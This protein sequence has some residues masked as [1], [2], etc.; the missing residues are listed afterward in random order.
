MISKVMTPDE[1]IAQ[2]K[3]GDSIAVGG[4][5]PV[6]KPMGLIR[7]IAR[8]NLKNLT[9]MSYAALEL[10]LLIGAK[11]V[12]KAIYGFVALEGAPGS[13]GNYQRARQG[14]EI[15]V[16]ELSEGMLL[17]GLKAAAERLPFC[18]TRSGLGTDLLGRCPEIEVFESPYTKEK[19]VAMPALE[20]DVAL[21][22]V[23][24]ADPSGYGQIQGDPYWDPLMVRAA[25]KVFL[26]AEK[27]V[28]LE[29]LKEDYRSIEIYSPWVTGVVEMPFGAHPGSCYPKYEWDEAHLK[30]YGKASA[31]QQSF[32]S[33][34]QKYVTGVAGEKD[35][36][37]LVKRAS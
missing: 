17:T 26:C 23:N 27:I 15:E 2:I 28:R 22:H 18:P 6:R 31:D 36:L 8:S 20:P 33:Y 37:K 13:L 11:K 35:Y 24:A 32:D 1:V 25:K 14:K 3:D 29:K 30:E 16:M 21:I 10:D 9:L 7:E 34:L 19:L 5:G 12:K 4:W